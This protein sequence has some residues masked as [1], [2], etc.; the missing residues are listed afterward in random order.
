MIMKAGE[1]EKP[2]SIEYILPSKT[3][4]LMFKRWIENYSSENLWI[5]FELFSFLI[6]AIYS[7]RPKSKWTLL[8]KYFVQNLNWTDDEAAMIEYHIGVGLRVLESQQP[9][10]RFAKRAAARKGDSPR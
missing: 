7:T 6:N 5:Q 1:A 3:A 8:R 9:Y 10:R 4:Q 2:L